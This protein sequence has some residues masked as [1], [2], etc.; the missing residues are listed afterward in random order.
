MQELSIY[1]FDHVQFNMLS[2]NDYYCYYFCFFCVFMSGHLSSLLMSPF[3][4]ANRPFK[5]NL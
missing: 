5:V 4:V 2:L 1:H 3:K